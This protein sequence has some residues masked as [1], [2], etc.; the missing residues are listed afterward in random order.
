MLTNGMREGYPIPRG[1]QW[2]ASRNGCARCGIR[3]SEAYS[4]R[5]RGSGGYISPRSAVGFAVPFLKVPVLYLTT[6]YTC[7]VGFPY[8][9]R[10]RLR[11]SVLILRYATL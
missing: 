9:H 6:N 11:A 8:H 2:S 7:Y 10:Y 4:T 1:T 3:S 5:W